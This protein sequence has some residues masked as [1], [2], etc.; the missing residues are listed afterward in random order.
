MK[1]LYEEEKAWAEE[2]EQTEGKLKKAEKA[3]KYEQIITVTFNKKYN[4]IELSFRFKPNAS[5]RAKLKRAGFKWHYKKMVWYATNNA[6]RLAA[7]G[8]LAGTIKYPED[9]E[10]PEEK[11]DPARDDKKEAASMYSFDTANIDNRNLAKRAAEALGLGF[12]EE[13][14]TT[15][16]KKYHFDITAY[17]FEQVRVLGIMILALTEHS[18]SD[19][20]KA[21]LLDKIAEAEAMAA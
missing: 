19:K 5:E 18:E 4:G 20:Y 11:K 21:E 3:G 8:T 1:N 17:D 15:C 2:M 9:M 14:R 6:D 12:S 10:K 7:V 16:C 13:I